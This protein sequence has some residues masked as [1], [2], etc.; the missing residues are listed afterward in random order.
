MFDSCTGGRPQRVA[1]P[2]RELVPPPFLLCRVLAQPLHRGDLAAELVVA[3]D[4]RD[5]GAAAIRPLHLGFE[6]APVQIHEHARARQRVAQPLG[7]DKPGAQRPLAG[8]RQLNRG[9]G[10]R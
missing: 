2:F 3:D 8:K 5:D 9:Q 10:F 6:A 4:E 7:Q 1:Q